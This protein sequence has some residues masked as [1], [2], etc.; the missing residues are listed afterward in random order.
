MKERLAN[1]GAI[2][3]VEIEAFFERVLND[4]APDHDWR[5]VGSA[6]HLY[7]RKGKQI[8]FYIGAIGKYPW[9]VKEEVLH[10]IAHIQGEDG[11]GKKFYSRYITLLS[12]FMQDEDIE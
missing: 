4:I 7:N 1:M 9:Q 10:E 12:M 11:H 6:P 5:W 2:T 8:W 3:K